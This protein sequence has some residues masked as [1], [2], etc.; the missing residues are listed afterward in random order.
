MY[1]NLKRKPMSGLTHFVHGISVDIYETEAA[2]L[3]G[4]S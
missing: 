3:T 1:A 4:K 2:V